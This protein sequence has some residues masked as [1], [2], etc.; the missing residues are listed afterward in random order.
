MIPSTGNPNIDSNT[1]IKDNWQ[2][3]NKVQGYSL[4]DVSGKYS[5]ENDY[6][7]EMIC[8]HLKWQ[9]ATHMD[10]KKYDAY[11]RR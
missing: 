2:E 1:A 5:E 3:P 10:I 4:A 6:N 11:S 7:T 9:A 8:K